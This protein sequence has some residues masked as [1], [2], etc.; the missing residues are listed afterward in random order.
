MRPEPSMLRLGGTARPAHFFSAS[1]DKRLNISAQRKFSQLTPK[2][3]SLPTWPSLPLTV[4]T[5]TPTVQT[6]CSS[7]VSSRIHKA[8]LFP[9]TLHLIASMSDPGTCSPTHC[10]LV[11]HL[12]SLPFCTA[13]RSPTHRSK[14]RSSRLA[15]YTPE[16]Q[17]TPLC[18]P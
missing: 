15:E 7:R 4:E 3:S 9:V 12:G 11:S 1:A 18:C 6:T 13:S 8:V 17:A 16:G 14:V 10:F 5:S 2:V